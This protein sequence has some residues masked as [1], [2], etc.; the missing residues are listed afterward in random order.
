MS[1]V[2]LR[3]IRNL[4]ELEALRDHWDVLLKRSASDNLF[5]SWEWISTWSRVYLKGDHL[6]VI[7]VYEGEEPVAIAPWWQ[8]ERRLAGFS[9]LRRLRFL[10]TGNVCSDYLDIIVR[11]DQHSQ[12]LRPIWQEL[13]GPLRSQWDVIEYSDTPAGSEALTCFYRWA[14]EDDRCLTR[15]VNQI[16]TCPYLSLPATAEEFRGSLSA[17]KR[18]ALS[19]SRRHFDARGSVTF[20]YSDCAHEVS[21]TMDRL[22]TLNTRSWTERG[23]SG[24]F[25]T[26]KFIRFHNEVAQ[27]MLGVRSL[28]LCSLWVDESY[29]GSF[30]GF[31]HGHVLYYYIMSVE[32]SDEN[33]VNAGDLLL[34]ECMEEGV[35]RGC[36]EFDFL[37]G[38]ESYK[39]RWTRTHRQNLSLNFYNR[40][41]R[42]ALDLTTQ[43]SRDVARICAKVF[44]RGFAAPSNEPRTAPN[45]SRQP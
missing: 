11:T 9:T 14:D 23:H 7:V 28:V 30:Y 4:H 33:H 42:A 45:L 29:L 19:R 10:G 21:A 8:E 17:T 6:F 25:A 38:D 16:T 1:M 41:A 15:R 44:A 3:L 36:S 43:S 13:F 40:S 18:Y 22:R 2:S 12:W 20:R 39:Y 34:A 5:L 37:R 27:S 35:R 32:R 31:Q 26:D 24:S